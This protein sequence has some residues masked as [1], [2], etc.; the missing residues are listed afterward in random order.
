MG[1]FGRVVFLA[2]VFDLNAAFATDDEGAGQH[3][4]AAGLVDGVGL[5]GQKRLVGL[6]LAVQQHGVGADLAAGVEHDDVVA[7]EFLDG[8]LL[9]FPVA[10]DGG[11]RG[12]EQGELLDELFR[13]QLLDDADQRI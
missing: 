7:H 12:G 10:H 2:D 3:V 5:A 13:T 1:E 4:V 6:D 11:A 8:E 9:D